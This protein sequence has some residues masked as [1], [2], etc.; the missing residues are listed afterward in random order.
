M[1][2]PTYGTE[3][4]S[5]NASAHCRPSEA[6]HTTVPQPASVSSSVR[7]TQAQDVEGGIQVHMSTDALATEDSVTA[8]VEQSRISNTWA[9]AGNSSLL[10]S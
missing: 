7:K 9:G 3:T 1:D 10:E 2:K 6:V 4:F 5:E 8:M